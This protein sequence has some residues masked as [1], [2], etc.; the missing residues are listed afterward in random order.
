[1]CMLFCLFVERG[2]NVV[3]II[4]D[5][6]LL[7]VYADGEKI[8]NGGASK[9]AYSYW[10]KNN[11]PHNFHISSDVQHLAVAAYTDGNDVLSPYS[12]YY[13]GGML[14]DGIY[15]Y[16]SSR[17]GPWEWKCTNLPYNQSFRQ[18]GDSM[19][20]PLRHYRSLL[21]RPGGGNDSL[22]AD[23]YEP[24]FDDSEW[25]EADQCKMSEVHT[26]YQVKNPAAEWIWVDQRFS[27]SFVLC[28]G[29]Q[30]GKIVS[31]ASVILYK[32]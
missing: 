19:Y 31:L 25:V 23:W 6:V 24:G 22:A 18:E 14:V 4:G 10:W 16:S 21:K 12:S 13:K 11:A 20:A 17:E 9:G 26:V 15:V 29:R 5:K 32:A 8:E 7:E 30:T 1:M 3:S 28:R 27:D 2:Q